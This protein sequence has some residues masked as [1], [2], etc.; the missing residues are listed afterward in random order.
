M[1]KIYP[2]Q[3]AVTALYEERKFPITIYIE[4]VAPVRGQYT[5]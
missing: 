3:A 4:H 1:K 5:T 2:E